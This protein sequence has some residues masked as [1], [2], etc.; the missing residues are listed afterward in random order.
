MAEVSL[1]SRGEPEPAA[2]RCLLFGIDF[3]TT[4]T[5]IAWAWT[6]QPDDIFT[7]TKWESKLYGNEEREKCPTTIHYGQDGTTW[8]YATPLAVEPI[9]WFKLL[10]VNEDDLADHLKD[11][12]QLAQAKQMLSDAGKSAIE[13]V[14][15]YLMHLWNHALE[16]VRRSVGKRTLDRTPFQV[17]LTIPAIWKAYA[18]ARMRRAAKQAGIL[19][20]RACGQTTLSFVT[21]PEAAALATF[22]DMRRRPDVETGDA[23]IVADCGG[24]TVDLISYE[25]SGVN[26]LEVKECVEGTGAL[27]GGTFLDEDF[28]ALLRM[29][30][31]KRAWDKIPRHEVQKMMVTTWE[32]GIKQQFDGKDLITIPLYLSSYFRWV[33]AKAISSSGHVEEVFENVISQIEGLVGHQLRRVREKLKKQP[34]YIILVGGFGRCR[35]LYERLSILVGDHS[36]VLQGSGSAPWTAVSRGAV[37]RALTA[38]GLLSRSLVHVS[39]RISRAS[40]GTE[41]RYPFDENKHAQEDKAFCKIEKTFFA[42]RQMNWFLVR[43]DNTLEKEP[44][45][46]TYYHV[47]PENK[48]NLG[49]HPEV[50]IPIFSCENLTP[51]SRRDPGNNGIKQLCMIQVRSPVPYSEM[52]DKTNSAGERLLTFYYNIEM[53]SY[54]A[55][56]EFS[57]VVDGQ[58]IASEYLS[59]LFEN[60]S[61]EPDRP[62][63]RIL[64]RTES[65]SSRSGLESAGERTTSPLYPLRDPMYDLSA[66]SALSRRSGEI[67]P[68]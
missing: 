52:P 30:V 54:G 38:R 26:P 25:V 8:G 33:D 36:E 61:S 55:S 20:D 59:V 37:I 14:A 53:I 50:C 35:F 5:G 11:S 66:L 39:S 44:T 18:V 19:A 56:V 47:W 58:R 17:V 4:Y 51:P 24:G 42:M 16:N 13:V 7:I 49:S 31:G 9:Q 63:S 48:V 29:R 6:G 27:C 65:E 28:E 2:K 60:V 3:G 64:E 67:N 12:P 43:G 34:R 68:V 45:R 21:E 15:D 1:D 10:L 41:A 62:V 46:L 22:S 23:F 40:F 32:H 57:V